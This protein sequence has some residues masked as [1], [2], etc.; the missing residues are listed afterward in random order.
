MVGAG[1]AI[2]SWIAGGSDDPV[3]RPRTLAAPTWTD[4]D[5][6]ASVR[7]YWHESTRVRYLDCG[8]GPTLVLLHGMGCCWEWWLE[9]LPALTRHCRVIA[10]DTPGFGESTCLPSPATMSDYADVVAGVLAHAGAPAGVVAG[11]S[12]GGLVALG[13]ARRHPE[14]V[15]RL[16]LV[17]S[18]GVPMSE[19]R[20]KVVLSVLRGAQRIFSHPRVVDL[21]V[22]SRTARSVLLRGAMRDPGCMSDELAAVIVPKLGAAGYADAITASAAAVRDSVPEQV[23]H[24][25]LLIWGERDPFAPLKT[26][27]EMLARLPA[28]R[29]EVI[30]GIGHTPLVE[31]PEVLTKLLLQ[32]RY[33]DA[34][35]PSR[36]TERNN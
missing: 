13:L 16:V 36:S 6:D 27:E 20:L 25:T 14:L 22:R 35:V 17:D 18:G 23:L 15:T 7:T 29:L 33:D 32:L 21:L 28:G 24:P 1:G 8:V 2:G 31:A 9:C 19:R 11:H 3:R 12:M 26:A 34:G 5:W 4:T 30:P 10:V